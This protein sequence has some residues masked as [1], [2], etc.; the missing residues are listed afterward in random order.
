M[1]TSSYTAHPLPSLLDRSPTTVA[2]AR[3]QAGCSFS[4]LPGPATGL[5]L[6]LICAII[7]LG[8]E[9]I[10]KRGAKQNGLL[11]MARSS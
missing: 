8:R 3:Q 6:R 9:D 1:C 5:A 2:P 10:R 7:R 4:L 11:T